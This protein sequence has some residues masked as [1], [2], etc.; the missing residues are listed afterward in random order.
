MTTSRIASLVRWPCAPFCSSG[1]GHH[2]HVDQAAYSRLREQDVGG[3]GGAEQ[4]GAHG[5]AVGGGD[6]EAVQRDVGGVQV[7]HDEEV[8]V[9]G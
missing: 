5:H 1:C 9:A 7:G 2:G 8:G 3:F 4:D 6:A